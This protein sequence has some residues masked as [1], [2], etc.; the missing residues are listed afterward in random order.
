MSIAVGTQT[1]VIPNAGT[2]STVVDLTNIRVGGFALPAA[3]TGT[4]MTFEVSH[5]GFAFQ[6]LSLP[7]GSLTVAQGKSYP[8]PDEIAAWPYCRFVSGSTEAGDRAIVV[9][10]KR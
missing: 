4:A 9:T 10:G 3:F 1:V 6:E 5:D 8:L 2:K 7:G